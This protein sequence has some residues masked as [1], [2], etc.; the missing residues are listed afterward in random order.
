[1]ILNDSGGMIKKWWEK[2]PIRFDNTKIDSFVIM[3]S[4]FHGIINIVG[5]RG[6]TPN[7]IDLQN[8]K[9][10][11]LNDIGLQNIKNRA[12]RAIRPYK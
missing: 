12:N 6:S 11:I 4:H 10:D 2:I 5:A 8:K 9:D 1:M 3:P 7:D